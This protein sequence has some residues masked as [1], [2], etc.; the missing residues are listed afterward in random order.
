M[1]EHLNPEEFIDVLEGA[2]VEAEIRRHLASCVDCRLELRDLEKTL[3]MVREMRSDAP[4]Y[5]RYALWAGAAAAILVAVAFLYRTAPVSGPN[6]AAADIELLAP[7]GEDSD[8][9]LLE[10]LS[11]Q[12]SDD[13]AFSFLQQDFPDLSELTS[14]ELRD[15]LDRLAR[16]MSSTS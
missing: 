1:S 7:I 6:E 11:Q 5:L 16:E 13:D 12:L 15:L 8:Y 2:P 14:P 10:A 4:A 3:G 9:Q